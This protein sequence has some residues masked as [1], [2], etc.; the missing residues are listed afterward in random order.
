M[1]A[2]FSHGI[3]IKGT[4][5]AY[6]SINQLTI[7]SLFLQFL[8][9]ETPHFQLNPEARMAVRVNAM[10]KPNELLRGK[11]EAEIKYRNQNIIFQF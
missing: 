9:H 10:G 8:F 7:L 3:V 5:Y 2:I 6:Q 4:K 1:I 11:S